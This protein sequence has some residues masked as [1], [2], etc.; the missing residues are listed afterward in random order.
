MCSR[1]FYSNICLDLCNKL[2]SLQHDILPIILHMM[3]T[4]RLSIQIDNGHTM[5]NNR[6]LSQKLCSKQLRKPNTSLC[7]T[8]PER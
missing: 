6:N 4:E 5:F 2:L 3:M 8:E 1:N 7:R